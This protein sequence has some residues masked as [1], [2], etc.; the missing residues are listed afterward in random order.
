MHLSHLGAS[1]KIP[2]CWKWGSCIHNQSLTAISSSSVL[3]NCRDLQS[4]A[5]AAQTNYVMRCDPSAYGATQAAHVRY[6]NA[7]TVNL[8]KIHPDSCAV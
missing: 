2:S 4:A 5:S 6:C 7:F 3:W 1:S 8:W